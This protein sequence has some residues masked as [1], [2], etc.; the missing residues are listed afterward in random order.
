MF[1][2][3][4]CTKE[5]R[6]NASKKVKSFTDTK[7]YFKHIRADHR[8]IKEFL[9][10]KCS[11]HCSSLKAYSKH[12]RKCCKT[13]S[14]TLMEI[15]SMED[16]GNPSNPVVLNVPELVNAPTEN[17]DSPHVLNAFNVGSENSLEWD[18]DVMESLTEIAL[19]FALELHSKANINRKN[20]FEIQVSVTSL[21]SKICNIIERKLENE[22]LSIT[23][24]IKDIIETCSNPFK[25][26]KTEHLFNKLLNEIGLFSKFQEFPINEA[27][28]VTFENRKS[29]VDKITN[30][31]VVMP[32]EFQIKEYLR[33]NGRI[34][35]M[36]ANYDNA[37]K[38]NG[39]V[40]SHL[41]QCKTW[42][43]IL[44]KVNKEPGT[45]LLPIG[46][47]A[48]GMQYNN[49]LGP[50][51]ESA[52]MVYYFSPCATDPLN[53]NNTFLA[54]VIMS[55]DVKS[56]GNGKCFYPLV[57]IFERL[58]KK[59]IEFDSDGET[60]KIKFCLSIITFDNLG[61][62]SILDFAKGFNATIFCRFCLCTNSESET[63]N[64]ERIDMLRTIENYNEGLEICDFKQTGIDAD[65]VFNLL[66]FFHCVENKSL[67]LM[68]DYFEGYGRLDLVKFITLLDEEKIITVDELNTRLSDF[69]YGEE[70]SK[71]IPP[72]L[73]RVKLRDNKTMKLTAKEMW[74]F[75]Y[76]FPIIVGDKIPENYEPWEI[77]TLLVQIIDILLGPTFYPETLE[78]L[79]AK[80]S[81]HHFL[82]NKYF[83]NLIPKMH[84]ATHVCT[85]IEAMG[86]PRMY[87][88]F[89]MESKHM[90][91]KIYAHAMNC[92]KNIPVSFATKYSYYFANFLA[93]NVKYSD[94][95]TE[96]KDE[97]STLYPH[98]LKA[99]FECF[100]KIKYRGSD[101]EAKM[102]VPIDD[103]LYEIQELFIKGDEIEI[104][105]RLVGDLYYNQN[106]DC[107]VVTRSLA[108]N[109]ELIDFKDIQSQALYIYKMFNGVEVIRKKHY[110]QN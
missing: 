29:R 25:E 105:C 78:L 51:T 41:V 87:M 62:N 48:D 36:L 69:G 31:G 44:Q 46:L 39:R 66:N 93:K 86:P 90:F 8:N 95:K 34:E 96:S 42:Q 1:S 45:V 64:V 88:A 28:G 70:D 60:I 38:G 27:L 61:L 101:Y 91:F 103:K 100:S 2:C 12:I 3:F 80:V 11:S 106:L 10:L 74:Q 20:V 57:E 49:A 109:V 92:R 99:G 21:I 24:G 7:R 97:A 9:C 54:A 84:L 75:I 67:D 26:M 102:F 59:G 16:I 15:D 40:I 81:R 71:Y 17:H 72:L 85:S 47:Y 94:I 19:D 23:E 82:F 35:E 107:Y 50:H 83:G 65:C 30:T 68:H 55:K 53:E 43:N 110:F 13:V 73:D 18:D 79:K 37:L 5:K 6:I 14:S 77:I 98:L 104:V 76:L 33:R 63:L 22:G 4:A 108:N 52:E 56:F 32:I 58:A 89:R